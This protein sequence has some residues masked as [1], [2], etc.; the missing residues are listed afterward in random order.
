M[1]FCVCGS[2]CSYQNCC[3]PY[4]K[5]QETP[6][7]PEAL[8]RSRYTAYTQA[9]IRYIQKTMQGK[10]AI[11]FNAADSRAWAERVTW[12]DLRV[13]KASDDGQ[14]G[15]VE[16]IARFIE[17]HHMCFIHENSQFL[18]ETGRWFYVDGKQVPHH[19]QKIARNSACPC[20]SG[21]KFK[22]CHGKA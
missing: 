9:D 10:A 3:E 17:N 19:A 1:L 2:Q 11:G 20:Q 7:T 12:I 8:M 4:L 6:S 21:K 13:V 22:Q 5:Y 16:F 15:H 14:T 18:Y